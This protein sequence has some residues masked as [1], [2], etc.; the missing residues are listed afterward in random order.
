MSADSSHPR[1]P[2]RGE[3]KGTE[4]NQCDLFPGQPRGSVV[5]TTNG[6]FREDGQGS[7]VTL[8]HVASAYYVWV[9]FGCITNYHKLRGLNQYPFLTTRFCR[10]EVQLGLAG[11]SYK[12][13]IKVSAVFLS[14]G[15]GEESASGCWPDSVPSG[16]RTETIISLL[17]A[18][19]H[20]HLLEA[21]HIPLP[22]KT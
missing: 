13:E 4:K 8:E 12:A 20:S 9:P 19:G 7:P 3:G 2:R 21:A 11:L 5:G 10:P 1:A 6:W 22:R 16:S 17:S 15:S 14:G 18:R